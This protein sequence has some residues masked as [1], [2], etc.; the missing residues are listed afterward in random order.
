MKNI[1]FCFSTLIT[2][3]IFGCKKNNDQTGNCTLEPDSG[4][5]LAYMPRYYYD[6]NEKKCKEFIWGGC[7]G[8]VPFKTL[9]ECKKQCGC[10]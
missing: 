7:D 1:I 6:K 3:T 4:S 2:L 9:K 8:V 10:K 5:C